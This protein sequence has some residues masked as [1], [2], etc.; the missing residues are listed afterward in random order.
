[1]TEHLERYLLDIH[2]PDGHGLTLASE[3]V[4][5]CPNA[6][7]VVLSGYLSTPITV[8]AVK[9]GAFDVLPKP[10]SIARIVEA[11]ESEISR[12]DGFTGR[13]PAMPLSERYSQLEREIIDEALSRCEWNISRAAR[14]LGIHRQSLQRK[15]RKY[16]VC[17]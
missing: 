9:S 10:A 11:L 3:I 16:P 4:K 14:A 8:A 7:V 1:M 2:F 6:R 12:S 5:K 15:L 13:P 17:S